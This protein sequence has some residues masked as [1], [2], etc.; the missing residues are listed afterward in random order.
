MTNMSVVGCFMRNTHSGFG[1][2]ENIEYDMYENF[3]CC[4]WCD[5]FDDYCYDY[6]AVADIARKL[7]VL[8]EA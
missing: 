8:C 5:L 3:E 1:Y 4:L 6:A 7:I 2:M